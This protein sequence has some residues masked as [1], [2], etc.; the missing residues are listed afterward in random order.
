MTDTKRDDVTDTKREDVTE[1]TWL[2]LGD[3]DAQDA[4]DE[5]ED[6]AHDHLVRRDPPA[7]LPEHWRPHTRDTNSHVTQTVT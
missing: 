2:H 4:Q 3:Q 1:R 6:E 5:Q 7:D